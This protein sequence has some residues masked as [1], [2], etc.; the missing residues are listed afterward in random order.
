MQSNLTTVE[1]PKA[2]VQLSCRASPVSLL[3]RTFLRSVS[4]LR[5]HSWEVTAVQSSAWTVPLFSET[6]NNRNRPNAFNHLLVE[7]GTTCRGTLK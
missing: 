5:T 3:A 1:V 6:K 7:R 2:S 4:A